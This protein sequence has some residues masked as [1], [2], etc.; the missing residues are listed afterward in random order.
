[1]ATRHGGS[2]MF[3]N[4]GGG[5]EV[6]GV[7]LQTVATTPLYLPFAGGQYW[8]TQ[9]LLALEAVPLQPL[10]HGFSVA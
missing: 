2:Y 9:D 8:Y 7:P 6:T 4:F 1:M 5:L 10:S 3:P